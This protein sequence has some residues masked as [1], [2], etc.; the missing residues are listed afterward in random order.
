MMEDDSEAVIFEGS[1]L[2]EYLQEACPNEVFESSLP[3]KKRGIVPSPDPPPKTKGGFN[4]LFTSCSILLFWPWRKFQLFD[5]KEAE[6]LQQYSCQ[7]QSLSVIC[8]SGLVNAR[9]QTLLRSLENHLNEETKPPHGAAAYLHMFT[10]V[11]LLIGAFASLSVPHID[12][13]VKLMGPL[14]EPVKDWF[15]VFLGISFLGMSF[16]IFLTVY[17]HNRLLCLFNNQK[18]GTDNYIHSERL[19]RKS[20][21]RSLQYIQEVEVLSRGYTMVNA[22]SY[23]GGMEASH[24]LLLPLRKVCLSVITKHLVALRE[25]TNSL[26]SDFP[27]LPEYKL[28]DDCISNQQLPEWISSA[29]SNSSSLTSSQDEE[30]LSLSTLKILFGLYKEQ[31]SDFVHQFAITLVKSDQL[32]WDEGTDLTLHKRWLDRLEGCTSDCKESMSRLDESYR[33]HRW[34]PP[35]QGSIPKAGT[36]SRREVWRPEVQ[37]TTALHSLRLHLETT[38]SKISP[39]DDQLNDC[40][41]ISMTDSKLSDMRTLILEISDHIEASQMCYEETKASLEKITSKVK[42]ET[43]LEEEGEKPIGAAAESHDQLIQLINYDEGDSDEIDGDMEEQ[44]FE[45]YIDKK[46]NTGRE[47]EDSEEWLQAKVLRRREA[48]DAKRLLQELNCVL[49]KR[50]EQ[51]ERNKQEKIMTKS[52]TENEKREQ[53]QTSHP[54]SA[55][56]EIND[57]ATASTERSGNV[58]PEKD[59]TEKVNEENYT[60][61]SK[62]PSDNT[63]SCHNRE[64]NPE[65]LSGH[66]KEEISAIQGVTSGDVYIEGESLQLTDVQ[67]GF[68]EMGTGKQLDGKRKDQKIDNTNQTGGIEA[69]EKDY[70]SVSPPRDSEGV[71]ENELMGNHL[72]EVD[73]NLSTNPMEDLQSESSK[74]LFESEGEHENSQYREDGNSLSSRDTEACAVSYESLSKSEDSEPLSLGRF[75]DAS[76]FPAVNPWMV[77]GLAA[78]VAKISQEHVQLSEDTFGDPDSDGDDE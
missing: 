40:E 63:E 67:S 32:Q 25:A 66:F 15:N 27:V 24:H 56:T 42:P 78:Q 62:A 70:V 22:A 14:P 51:K 44:I 45:A 3:Q 72:D 61:A 35:S 76:S 34:T 77:P 13:N 1:P 59:S 29:A 58:S 12:N 7:L 38:L 64:L 41:V 50:S 73:V 19:F 47:D 48:E 20:F 5:V 65:N 28:S 53:E 31:C 30:M 2:Y 21:R 8:K 69:Y 11:V 37:L 23:S 6:C 10:G 43:G 74:S 54:T 16:S 57:T 17:H 33:L 46:R 55:K 4:G 71:K 18:K 9:D 75:R 39:I 26:I 49:T 68:T 60:T 36:V 52:S